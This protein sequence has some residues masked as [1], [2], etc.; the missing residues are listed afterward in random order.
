VS[1]ARSEAQQ[2]CDFVLRLR[3]LALRMGRYL[4]QNQLRMTDPNVGD[5]LQAIQA[6]IESCERALSTLDKMGRPL[7]DDS[8]R[9]WFR[10]IKYV[11]D[12]DVR[13]DQEKI[14]DNN[15]KAMTLDWIMLLSMKTDVPRAVLPFSNALRED[16]GEWG[17][18][19]EQRVAAVRTPDDVEDKDDPGL[20]SVEDEEK[21]ETWK[22]PS[23]LEGQSGA[24]LFVAVACSS[25]ERVKQLLDAGCDPNLRDDHRRTLVHRACQNLDRESLIHL[26]QVQDRLPENCLNATDDRGDTALMLL[27]KQADYETSLKMAADLLKAGCDASCVN[28]SETP[29]D[30]LYYA[31]DAPKEK[32]RVAFVRMLAN[33]F[34]ANLSIIKEA[35]PKAV[36]LY[37]TDSNVETDEVAVDE[38]DGDDQA[39]AQEKTRKTSLLTKVAR[40]LS[41]GVSNG[42]EVR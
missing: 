14:L 27:A 5:T 40:R 41:H 37:L 18:D 10:R 11:W 42:T 26:L 25:S 30:A 7:T 16:A 35:F 38:N 33:D 8:G 24:A 23:F 39:E 9:S 34:N 19:L 22:F 21:M 31:M 20:P 28:R 29:R 2:L 32:H 3:G 12:S 1:K 4:E 6:S 13:Q 15:V 36:R 17:R